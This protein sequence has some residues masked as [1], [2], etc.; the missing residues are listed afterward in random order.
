MLPSLF[1]EHP[2]SVDETYVEHMGVASG[3][4]LRMLLGGMAC[5]V[6]AVLP[7]LCVTTGSETIGDLHERMVANRR[8]H[9]PGHL[10]ASA[11]AAKN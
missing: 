1:T 11:A 3:F 8:R 2:T 9:Q 6:H 5:L 4:G 7:F 10:A